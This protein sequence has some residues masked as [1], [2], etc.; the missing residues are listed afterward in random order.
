MAPNKL[1]VSER[2]RVPYVTKV[3][4]LNLTSKKLNFSICELLNHDL[5]SQIIWRLMERI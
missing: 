1:L 4:C 5:G 2:R 3:S